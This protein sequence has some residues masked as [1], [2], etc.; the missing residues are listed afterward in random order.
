MRERRKTDGELLEA[1][2]QEVGDGAVQFGARRK[3]NDIEIMAQV[4][5]YQESEWEIMVEY[6]QSGSPS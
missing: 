3:V 5:A 6:C 1:Y 4:L 2:K